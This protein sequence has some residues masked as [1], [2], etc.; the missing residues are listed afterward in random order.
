MSVYFERGA[1]LGSVFVVVEAAM[2]FHRR[3]SN[4]DRDAGA[5]AADVD[6]LVH[7]GL[8]VVGLVARH[9]VK[10]V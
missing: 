10:V 5:V 1:L 7:F 8:G 9:G 2:K 3:V 6:E 4:I